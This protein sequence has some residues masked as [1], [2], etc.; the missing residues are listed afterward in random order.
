MGN[1][2]NYYR[3]RKNL[4]KTT[5]V[6]YSHQSLRKFKSS[7]VLQIPLETP[8][9]I[10]QPGYLFQKFFPFIG[11]NIRMCKIEQLKPKSCSQLVYKN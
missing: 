3:T 1:N 2:L 6:S 11:R 4:A 10:P 8:C 5:Q 9:Q 7:R